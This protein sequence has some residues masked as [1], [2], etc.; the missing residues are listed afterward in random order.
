MT[1]YITTAEFTDRLLSGDKEIIQKTYMLEIRT[2][3]K[4]GNMQA[5]RNLAFESDNG[6]ED[7]RKEIE[8]YQDLGLR[9]TAELYQASE[10]TFRL[11]YTEKQDA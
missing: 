4:E 6:A 7:I 1:K 11:I 9:Y 8:H 10:R 2:K 3:D 5:T